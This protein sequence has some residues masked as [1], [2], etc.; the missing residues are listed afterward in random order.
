MKITVRREVSSEIVQ[1]ITIFRCIENL[2]FPG[3]SPIRACV[4]GNGHVRS[5]GD[6]V[7]ARH[8]ISEP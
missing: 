3:E 2:S 4:A 1:C 7:T 5:P 8:G 6:N